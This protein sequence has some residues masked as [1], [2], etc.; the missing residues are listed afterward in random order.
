M[1][2]SKILNFFF[3]QHFGI[4][5]NAFQSMEWETRLF[6]NSESLFKARRIK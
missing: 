6:N 4:F 2:S 3:W 5:Q 1:T